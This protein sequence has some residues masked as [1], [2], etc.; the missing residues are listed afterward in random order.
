MSRAGLFPRAMLAHD[1]YGRESDPVI[2]LIHGWPLDRTIWS[3]VAP[4]IAAAGFRVLTPDLPGFGGSGGLDEGRWTVEGYAEELADF[5]DEQ[6]SGRVA[7]AGHSFGGYVAL[8]LAEAEP[9][10]L[11]ALG[12]VSSRTNAD[13]EAAKAGRL[14]T[15]EKVRAGGAAILLPDLAARL[16]AADATADLRARA[17]A[18]IR[19]AAPSA[20][21][22][23]LTAMAARPDRTGVLES[24]PRSLLV[25]HGSA[26]QLIP[27]AEAAQPARQ[28]GPL[29]RVI[30]DRVGHMPT[31]EAPEKTVEAI[32]TWARASHGVAAP[33]HS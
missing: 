4:T 23:G 17:D 7:V 16:L 1:A 3:G 6:T 29:D 26:D 13:S 8:A 9:S 2:F 30:L 12:L 24:F 15:I 14:A 28:A 27:V 21:I 25:L 31:W 18:L 32:L 20:I 22:S 19:R 10:R 11:A 33:P 5:M